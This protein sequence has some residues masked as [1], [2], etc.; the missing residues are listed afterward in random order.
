MQEE[1]EEEEEEEEAAMRGPVSSAL[2][3]D[4]RADVSLPFRVP[5]APV[6][7][8]KFVLYNCPHVLNSKTHPRDRHTAPARAAGGG[9]A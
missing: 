7:P 9:R 5:S 8:V 6:P 2:C 3:E 1:E 4:G